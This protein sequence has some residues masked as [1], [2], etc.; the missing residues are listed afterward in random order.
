MRAV[1]LPLLLCCACP[2]SP[3]VPT[4]G[5]TLLVDASSLADGGITDAGEDFDVG[6]P[7]CEPGCANNEQCVE[8]RCLRPC[9]CN[10]AE[11]CDQSS[12]FCRPNPCRSDQQCP[13]EML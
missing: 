10:E 3:A 5:G 4:D 13:G 11:R 7:P 6:P 12:G 9:P 8:H 1:L 2:D